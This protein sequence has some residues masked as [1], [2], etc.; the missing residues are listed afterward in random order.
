MSQRLKGS[1]VTSS[2]TM[3][4]LGITFDSKLQWSNQVNNC[5]RKSI[6]TLHAIRLIKSHFTT[7]EQKKL[8]TSNFNLILYYNSEIWHL[9]NLYPI[10]KR[11]LLS[12]SASALKIFTP[13]Y[14]REMSFRELHTL[15]YRVTPI[16]F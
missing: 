9:P 4:V 6:R 3:N 14:N 8:I 10:S 12:A 2:S 5:I 7:D 1:K 16:N 13:T 15:N 11:H